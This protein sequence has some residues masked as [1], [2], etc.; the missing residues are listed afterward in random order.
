VADCLLTLRLEALPVRSLISVRT[1]PRADCHWLGDALGVPWQPQP[2]TLHHAE[3]L[4]WWSTAPGVWLI[5]GPVE[6][7]ER[8]YRAADA[9][10]QARVAMVTVVSDAS[11]AL[12]LSGSASALTDFFERAGP[13]GS[14]VLAGRC[15]ATRLGAFAITMFEWPD[16]GKGDAAARR[17]IELRVERP[18]LGSLTQ[19]LMQLGASF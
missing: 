13:V 16:G 2:M 11:C 10:S 9:A 6:D 8:L 17:Q 12:G 19:W 15:V 3:G 14:E 5:D 4:R 7:E 1:E 18:L